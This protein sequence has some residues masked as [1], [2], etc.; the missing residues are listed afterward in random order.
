MLYR[1]GRD[2]HIDDSGQD[3]PLDK[4]PASLANT[5]K[6]LALLDPSGKEIDRIAYEKAKAGI[7][8]ERSE[9]GFYL[10]TDER[11]ARRV[12]QTLLLTMNQK[13]RI[14]RTLP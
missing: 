14:V 13:I 7:A 1:S 11:G 2:I 6:E 5:G 12:P 10:S 9:I 4:F 3:I 8:W